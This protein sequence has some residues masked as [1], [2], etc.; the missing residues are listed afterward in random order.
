M[1]L[2]IV[3]MG[4]GGLLVYQ[5]A[6]ALGGGASSEMVGGARWWLLIPMPVLLVLGQAIVNEPDR[7]PWLFPFVNVALVSIPSVVIASVAARRYR[8][9]NRWAWPVS[10]R[11]WQTG[12]LYGALGATTVAAIL[13]VSYLLGLAVVLTN[14]RGVGEYGAVDGLTEMPRGWRVFYDVSVFSG[15]GPLNEE[16]WKGMLVAFF[17]FRHGSAGRCFLW[18]ALAGAGF[19][20][21]ETFGNSLTLVNPD[22]LADETISGTWWLFGVMRSGTGLLHAAASGMAALG[23]YGLLRRRWRLTPLFLA[24]WALHGSWNFMVY[25]VQGDAFPA[26]S[27]PDSVALDVLGFA[28]AVVLA[29]T[30]ALILWEFPRRFRDSGPAPVYRILGMMP[31]DA[32]PTEQAQ[33]KHEPVRVRAAR[34]GTST[35]W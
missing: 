11:E 21:Y 28:G 23:I 26:E 32:T 17:F 9:F 34:S 27:A 13:N 8:A 1:G 12:L 4:L 6:S 5:A 35:G 29:A 14:A 25:V 7:L 31:E 30:S 33:Y 3:G 20:L 19:N 10:W 16:F 15:F 22:A 24:G 2:A 18:G